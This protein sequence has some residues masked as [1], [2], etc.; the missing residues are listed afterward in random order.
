MGMRL[1]LKANYDIS[2]FSTNVQVILTALKHYG[3]IMADNG[4]AMYL[5]GSPDDRWDNNDLHNLSQVPASAFEVVQMNP[6]YTSTNIP[7]GSAPAITSFTANSPNAAPGS[8]VT[9]NWQASGASYY[10]VTPQVGAVRGNTVTVAPTQ[11]TVYTLY[12]TNQYG[13]TSAA[14]TVTVQ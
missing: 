3:M 13:R 11:T 1:R 6:I 5:S 14:L 7:Q 10:V 9:L 4:S 2:Q 12:A 8:Q